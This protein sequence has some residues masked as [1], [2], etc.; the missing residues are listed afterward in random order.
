MKKFISLGLFLSLF[1]STYVL[2]SAEEFISVE[3]VFEDMSDDHKNA[4]AINFLYQLEVIEG[5]E[6]EDG[7]REYRPDQEVNRA[8]F[9][10]ILMGGEF[11]G[12]EAPSEPCFPDVQET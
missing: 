9:L 3:D 5:Y 2:A 8:E 6:N 11:T 1:F 4:T 12:F 10:K 7:T